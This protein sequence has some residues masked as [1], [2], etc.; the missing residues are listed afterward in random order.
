MSSKS[1]ENIWEKNVFYPTDEKPKGMIFSTDKDDKLPKVVF[2]IV[3]PENHDMVDLEIWNRDTPTC[4]GRA[5]RLQIFSSSDLLSW[6]SHDLTDMK[7]FVDFDRPLEI[8]LKAGEKFLMITKKNADSHFHLGRINLKKDGLFHRKISYEI[9]FYHFVAKFGALSNSQRLQD[10]FALYNCGFQDSYFLEF[11]IANGEALSNTLLLEAFGWRGI[12]GEALSSSFEQARAVRKCIVVQGALAAESGKTIEFFQQGLIS[13]AVNLAEV[14][15]H[16]K[17]RLEG[18]RVECTTIRIDE[19]LSEN[20]APKDIGFLSLDVEGAEVEVLETFPFDKV[21]LCCAAIEHN[22]T[23]A[24]Q[25]IDKIMFRNGF[26]RVLHKLSGHDGFYV[27]EANLTS[28][29]P[30]MEQFE[31]VKNSRELEKLLAFCH[32]ELADVN[33]PGYGPVHPP[34]IKK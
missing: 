12:G 4:R 5:K 19:V 7:A 26:K 33:H 13:S 28:T 2:E 16:Y 9:N 20:K 25:K 27:K 29:P 1:H 22:Y 6:R 32:N 21:N 14:D 31:K 23:K 8:S 3:L 34:I 10:I 24:E 17:K 18:S 15:Q 11:G 30:Y